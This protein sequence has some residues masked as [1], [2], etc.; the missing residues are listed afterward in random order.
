MKKY[1]F[2]MA[3][4]SMLFLTGCGEGEGQLPGAGTPFLGGT[5]G[6][7]I[8]FEDS[9]PA[10]VF[11]G[12][13]FPFD[14]VVRLKNDGEWDIPK[15]NIK[16]KISGIR[17]EQFNLAESQLAKN[18][19]E[20]LPKKQRDPTGT[21]LE[22]PP[23]LVEFTNFNH[24]ESITGS[25]LTYPIRADVCYRY[26]TTAVSQLCVRENI[27]NPQEGGICTINEA[28]TLFNSAAPVQVTSFTE[29]AR[30]SE[31]VGFSFTITHS[32]TGSIYEQDTLCNKESMAFEDRIYVKVDAGISG[33]E[34]SGLS[35]ETEGFVKLFG[36]TKTVSCTLTIPNPGDYQLPLRIDLGYDYES[37]TSTQILVRHSGE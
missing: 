20:D 21:L 23:V 16:V 26:G 35:E 22:S 14:I 7:S 32:G 33:L 15:N 12:G 36:G 31:K 4:I 27:L 2:A 8:S 1:I 18:A 19:P 5:S 11:D 24:R 34:C 29:S 37:S 25:E 6:V 28:K 30:S 17:A 13:D 9:P 10:E 3:V